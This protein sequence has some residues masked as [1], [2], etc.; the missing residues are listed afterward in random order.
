M[1]FIGLK[2]ETVS[3]KPIEKHVEFPAE[4]SAATAEEQS[5]EEKPSTKG[6]GKK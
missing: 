5:A 1:T 2:A 6:G 4:V 3:D